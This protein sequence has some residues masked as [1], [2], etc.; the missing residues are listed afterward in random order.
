MGGVL[1]WAANI[2]CCVW[3][4]FVVVI[5]SFPNVRPVTA[6]NMNYAAPI[7]VGVIV[8][9]GYGFL[10]SNLV[11]ML[12]RCRLWYVA[13]AHKHYTGPRSNVENAAATLIGGGVQAERTSKDAEKGSL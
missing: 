11:Q 1:G 4:A 2:T 9:S 3:T 8:L 6:E 13:G 5:F 10:P 7:T 12:I